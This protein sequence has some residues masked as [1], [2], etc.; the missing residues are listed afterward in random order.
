MT[1]VHIIVAAGCV[2]HRT[3]EG[4]PESPARLAAA[5]AGA[6]RVAGIREEAAL[7]AT[8]EQLLRVHDRDY[9]QQVETLSA[10]LSED[11]APGALDPD[12]FLGPGSR[13]AALLATGATVQAVLRS[14][15]HH[16][17]AMALGRPPGHHA[18]ARHAQGFC[19]YNAIAVA[20][21]HALTLPG[22]RRVAICDFDVHHGNGTEAL[23][24][25][26]EEVLFLSS[27][28]FPLYPGTG[29]P[30]RPSAGN[31]VNVGLPP[32]SGSDEFRLA[33]RDRLLPRL[34]AFRP[35]LLLVSAGFDAHWLDP[36]A[37]LR[38][39]EE[40]YFWIGCELTRAAAWS[41]DGRL[42]AT[43]EGGYHLDA[44]RDSVQAFVEGLAAGR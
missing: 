41:C 4:H 21:S 11:D 23:V 44:L 36:L 40:D 38:L 16:G 30:S 39:K 3:P 14:V 24:A 15:E 5:I 18:D 26:R 19:I 20:A 27:H 10:A 35:D 22:I 43:L 1:P 31:V 17:P 9:L 2:R 7:P 6:R 42:A 33:W 12:T 13:E 29:D 28:Q 8:P 34:Q 32:G 37:G 25:G